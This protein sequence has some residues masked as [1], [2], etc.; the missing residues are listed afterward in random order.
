MENSNSGARGNSWRNLLSTILAIM[1]III[2]IWAMTTVQ[3]NVNAGAESSSSATITE[4][5]LV[6]V[7]GAT[8]SPGVNGTDGSSGAQGATG[9]AGAD[10]T[11]GE[12]G[13]DGSTGATGACGPTGLTGKPG[14]QGIQGPVGPQG[15]Q[16][17][18][19]PVGDTGATGAT[20]DR[21]ATGATGPQGLRGLTGATGPQGPQ[22]FSNDCHCRDGTQDDRQHHPA[23]GFDQ[24]PHSD[25]PLEKVRHSNIGGGRTEDCDV[26]SGR[27][28]ITPGYLLEGGGSRQKRRS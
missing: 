4:S 1:A 22:T 18:T 21:G 16:G 25:S 24:F 27:A 8:G 10:G 2:S 17:F 7:A 13:R 26:A 15:V 3:S 5:E 6:C 19:G 28:L 12:D 9:S 11:A 23:A 14:I 20:G